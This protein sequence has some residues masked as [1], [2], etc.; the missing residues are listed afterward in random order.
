MITIAK[1]IGVGST[2]QL[3]IF[4]D[5]M[6]EVDRIKPVSLEESVYIMVNMHDKIT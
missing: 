2:Y 6:N 4:V 5:I 3:T 1:F